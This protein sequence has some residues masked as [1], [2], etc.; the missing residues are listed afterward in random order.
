VPN[1]IEIKETFCGLTDVH[2]YVHTHRRTDGHLRPV[3]LGRLCRRVDLKTGM[4]NPGKQP[5]KWMFVTTYVYLPITKTKEDNNKN[6]KPSLRCRKKWLHWISVTLT[7]L[8]LL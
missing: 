8:I 3:L 6:D 4:D 7:S 2:M 1:F 5:L